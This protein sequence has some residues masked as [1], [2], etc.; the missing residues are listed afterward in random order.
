MALT[1]SRQI[2][3][4]YVIKASMMIRSS[5]EKRFKIDDNSKKK[6]QLCIFPKRTIIKIMILKIFDSKS[7]TKANLRWHE[8]ENRKQVEEIAEMYV[9][10]LDNSVSVGA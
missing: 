6:I 2:V 1:Q 9:L 5:I 8:C 4:N 3:G 7:R 10:G